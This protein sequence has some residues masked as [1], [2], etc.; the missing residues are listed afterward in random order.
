MLKRLMDILIS[1]LMLVIGSPFFLL[2]SGL[3]KLTDGGPVF[4]KQTR[5]GLNGKLFQ[6]LKFR[7]MVIDAEKEKDALLEKYLKQGGI[8]FKLENDP[9]VTW[10]GRWLRKS[11]VDE[12]P[13]LWN[14]IKGEMSLVGPRPPLPYE[15][16]KYGPLER[17]R[18]GAKPGLTCL[19]QVNG[20]SD[21]SFSH[22]V[23]LDIA[24]IN[25][26][27]FRLDVEILMRTIPVVLTGRGAY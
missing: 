27:S 4:F 3:I 15:V 26:R 25:N 22:Q 9:R 21:L 5:V 19:W 1:V 20:R 8:T 14:V 2:V 7:S 17:K 18:L 13:Q 23:L 16:L 11:S 10:I 24:Y 12:M 6:M